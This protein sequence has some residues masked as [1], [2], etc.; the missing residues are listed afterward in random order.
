MTERRPIVLINGEFQ[1]LP[2]G[3]TLPNGG[4]GGNS[5]ELTYHG[6]RG[7]FSAWSS[8]T[9]GAWI[10]VPLDAEQ[11]DTDGFLDVA[12]ANP[13]RFTIPAGV[14]RIRITTSVWRN[15]GG[16]TAT[17][18]QWKISKNGS[19]MSLADGT[20]NIES[21][22]NGYNNSGQSGTS[23]VLNVV[24]GDY[25]DLRVY[26]ATANANFDG[27]LEIEV[28]EGSILGSFGIGS[29]ILSGTIDPTTE[30]NDGDLYINTTSNTLFGPKTSGTWPSGVSLVG[31][32]GADG[33]SGPNMTQEQINVATYSTIDADFAG[34]K[35]KKVTQAC[36][37]TIQPGMIN[38]QPVSFLATTAGMITFTAGTGV[39]IISPDGNLVTR[40]QGSPVTLVQD[41]D[42]AETYYLFGDLA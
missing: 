23:A 15:T 1:E 6:A 3:D 35:M 29:L 14:T 11:I 17:S 12:G 20:F 34:G 7:S 22:N 4:G 42:V 28:L 40:V 41:S 27:W 38:T 2:S 19:V 26:Q 18:D 8:T 16:A 39:T 30:G 32:T 36:T 33:P 37:V 21:M 9:T 5:T 13:E 24:E 25:F 31:P 10:K